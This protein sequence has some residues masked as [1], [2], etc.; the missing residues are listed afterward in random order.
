MNTGDYDNGNFWLISDRPPIVKWTSVLGLV[1]VDT[2]YIGVVLKLVL[3]R[4]AATPNGSGNSSGWARR[5]CGALR[6][7]RPK[8]ERA[9]TLYGD[10]TGYNAKYRKFFVRCSYRLT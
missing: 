9:Q 6:G 1:V 10:L 8:L 2:C 7:S 4:R 3:L 5:M